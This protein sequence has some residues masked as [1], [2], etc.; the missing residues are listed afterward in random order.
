MTAGQFNP[1]LTA[2][3]GDPV[4]QSGF[5]PLPNLFLRHYTQLGI[6]NSQ[7]MFL[8]QIMTSAWDLGSPANT[9]SQVAA[10]MGITRRGAQIISADL[11][12]RGLV[13]IYDQYD[14]TG[15]QTENAFD[16]SPLFAR[17]AAFAPV[18]APGGQQRQRRCRPQP[19]RD[20][21]LTLDSPSEDVVPVVPAVHA[22]VPGSANSSSSSLGTPVRIPPEP[23]ITERANQGSQLNKEAKKKIKNSGRIEQQQPVPVV[24]FDRPDGHPGESNRDSVWEQVK[25]QSLRLGQ[26]LNDAMI[27]RS[28]DVL[29]RIG[30]NA[31]V[32][33]RVA[34]ALAPEE[35]WAIWLHARTAH[36]GPAWVATQ[37][38]DR[39][40]RRPRLTGIARRFDAPGRLLALLPPP[41]AEALLDMVE[42][43]WP[44]ESKP[45]CAL[46]HQ[47]GLSLLE[48][49]EALCAALE[50][51][52][53]ALEAEHRQP[54]QMPTPNSAPHVP[55]MSD[56]RWDAAR[57]HLATVLPPAD[58]QTWIA[59]LVPI[60]LHSDVTVLGV[61]NVFVRD[62]IQVNFADA[63]ANALQ[64]E[65][66]YDAP[67]EII[68]DSALGMPL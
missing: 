6:S 52:W 67:V 57:Q 44:Q 28:R 19:R 59:P 3:F 16:L 53:Q 58:F 37:I 68:I 24:A 65:L 8:M 30:I 34:A 5:M 40:Q 14:E 36:L 17:L 2:Y 31:D 61:P 45:P 60:E 21:D 9:L 27:A 62:E 12:A 39:R 1:R 32:A 49:Q 11:H 15:R 26:P 48:N 47:P 20:D 7:A 33:D 50:A 63:L 43:H 13:A 55:A 23:Q 42:T 66:G 35:C 56:P 29:A 64:A 22:N 51:I 38:Y 46:L 25:G 54:R 10:R 41:A 18:A 4:L